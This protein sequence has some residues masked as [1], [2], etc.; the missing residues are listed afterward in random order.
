[1]KG[2]AFGGLGGV[3]CDEVIGVRNVDRFAVVGD[4]VAVAWDRIDV[5]ETIYKRM[6]ASLQVC[7]V[8]GYVPLMPS[9]SSALTPPGCSN[10]PT[11][12]SGSFKLFSSK[13]TLL[14]WFPKATAAAHPTM[15][16]PTMTTSASW[17]SSRLFSRASV[18]YVESVFVVGTEDVDV[19]RLRRCGGRDW[20]AL[21]GKPVIFVPENIVSMVAAVWAC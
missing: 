10:S 3:R 9:F 17:C 5:V 4:L 19:P 15:P 20:V 13:M 18:V 14:P 7:V 1:M 2:A 21:G 11:I 8:N 6:L 16:A 12:L